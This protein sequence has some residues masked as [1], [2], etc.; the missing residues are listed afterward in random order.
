MTVRLGKMP[1]PSG[2]RAQARP[3]QLVGPHAVDVA[4]EDVEA[5]LR[6]LHLPAGHA[7][8]RRLPG[9]VRSE[10]RQHRPVGHREVDAVEDLD[11]PVGGV[12][13]PQLQDGGFSHGP[14]PRAR[15]PLRRGPTL[16]IPPLRVLVL[17][18]V[19]RPQVGGAHTI[20]GPH[21]GGGPRHEHGAE[22]EDV[23]VGADPHHELHVVLDEQDAHA[24]LGQLAE[25]VAE[26]L[27]LRVAQPRGRL[28]EQE[29]ARP[30][31][32]RPGQLE[33]AGLPGGQGV[34]RPAGQRRQP[35]QG[36]DGVGVG[37]GVGPVVRPA[38]ADLRGGQDV[39]TDREGAEDLEPLEGAGDAQP[40]PL[41]GLEP[42][43]V[44]AVEGDPTGVDGLEA[45][46]GVEARGLA[47]SVGADEAGHGARLDREV[48]PAQRV[49]AAESNLGFRHFQKR[50]SVSPQCGWAGSQGERPRASSFFS[51]SDQVSCVRN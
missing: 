6:R 51:W 43:H 50:H 29:E 20:V 42:G 4:P 12:D 33:Q 7:Q 15:S 16:P 24:A 14:P 41:V 17:G 27:A 32:Q 38:T 2:K 3:G 19:G 23:D 47:G 45:A 49:H 46:N 26:L 21:L 11:L 40:G 48:D 22:V 1:R 25:Q 35:D 36:E 30:R 8:R 34:G 39:L 37:T 44:G 31:G 18:I 13:P 28:V 9:P 10:Q 5:P